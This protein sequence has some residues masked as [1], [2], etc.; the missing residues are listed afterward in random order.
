MERSIDVEDSWGESFGLPH[1]DLKLTT[2]HA[3]S[4]DDPRQVRAMPQQ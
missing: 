2:E 1:E 3:P 4:G